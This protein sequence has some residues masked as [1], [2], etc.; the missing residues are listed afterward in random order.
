MPLDDDAR[1]RA[2]ETKR[3][4][5]SDAILKAAEPLY[6]AG[7][8]SVPEVAAR[9]GVSAATIYRYYPTKDELIEAVIGQMLTPGEQ[10]QGDPA[11]YAVDLGER[12]M[13]LLSPMAEASMRDAIKMVLEHSDLSRAE[14]GERLLS[15][16]L[17]DF[18]WPSA[19]S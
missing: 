11:L 12:I 2:A 16:L 18:V 9:A 4:R 10:M 14:V 13:A 5:T 19:E 1:R 3:Q 6:M 8:L 17:G 15:G 7:E